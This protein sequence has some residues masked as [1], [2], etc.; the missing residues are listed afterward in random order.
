VENRHKEVGKKMDEKYCQIVTAGGTND[1]QKKIND[2]K[3]KGYKLKQVTVNTLA[4]EPLI[5]VMVK[6]E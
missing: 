4:R 1:L 2:L 5:A 6:Q 3:E